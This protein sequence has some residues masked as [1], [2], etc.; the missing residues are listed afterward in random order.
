IRHTRAQPEKLDEI[1]E[2]E[3]VA[4]DLA[5]AAEEGT[6]RPL[7]LTEGLIEEGH[8]AQ[9][10]GAARGAHGGPCEYRAGRAERHDTGGHL[11]AR[12]PARERDLF[13]AQAPARLAVPGAEV[14]A[15]VEEA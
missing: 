10:D 1:F 14:R 2:K 7:P 5:E 4:V 3:T 15:Q 13:L 11:G 8:V 9:G 6:H 12:Q